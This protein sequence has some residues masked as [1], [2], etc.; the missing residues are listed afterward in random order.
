M[1]FFLV[2][3]DFDQDQVGPQV[4]APLLDGVHHGDRGFSTVRLH[5][6]AP[7]G[8]SSAVDLL[9]QVVLNDCENVF[10]V[11]HYRHFSL[12]RDSSCSKGLEKFLLLVIQLG[13]KLRVTNFNLDVVLIELESV[14]V[15]IKCYFFIASLLAL[16]PLF[17]Q[18][19]SKFAFHGGVLLSLE[20]GEG[21]IVFWQ[22]KIPTTSR[23][24]LKDLLPDGFLVDHFSDLLLFYCF[25]LLVAF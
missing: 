16:L 13:E 20:H 1:F 15:W 6:Q 14:S 9:D 24:F 3:R 7:N 21:T 10:V 19:G 23:S 22:V 25:L 4:H 5:L 11:I 17:F 18:L 12:L 8:H 2:L